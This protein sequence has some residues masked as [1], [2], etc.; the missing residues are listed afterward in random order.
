M[1]LAGSVPTLMSDPLLQRVASVFDRSVR[2]RG[3]QYYHDGHVELIR[4][5]AESAYGRVYGSDEYKVKAVYAPAGRVL[6]V[7]CD[8]P[9]VESSGQACKHIW[10]M[11]LA[12]SE[13][14]M[15]TAA[16]ALE[17]VRL[18]AGE[19]GPEDEWK[20][21]EPA[22]TVPKVVPSIVPPTSAT[23]TMATARARPKPHPWRQ[24]LAEV[25]RASSPAVHYGFQWPA[26]RQLMYVIDAERTQ[27]DG[28]LTVELRSRQTKSDGRWGKLKPQAIPRRATDL[29][30]DTSDRQII[31]MMYGGENR[32]DLYSGYYEYYSEQRSAFALAPALQAELTRMIC[33]TG[34][35]MLR[36]LRGMRDELLTPL[37]WDE[38]PPWRFRVGVDR[39]GGGGASPYAITGVF[40]REGQTMLPSRAVLLTAG[41]VMIT[42]THA[43]PLHDSRTIPWA[44][45]LRKQPVIEVPSADAD[46]MLETLFSV[47]NSPPIELPEELAVQTVRGEPTPCLRIS[48]PDRWRGADR[49][50]AEWSF[51]Y[52]GRVV[53]WHHAAARVF[54][55]AARRVIERDLER[56]HLA[57]AQLRGAGFKDPPT[58]MRDER[59]LE[60]HP[61]LLTQAV[62]QLI[63]AGWRVEAEGKVYRTQGDLRINVVSGTDWFELQGGASFDGQEVS[64][65]ELLAAIRSGTNTIALGDGSI[66]VL[67]EAW[68]ERYGVLAGLGKTSGDHVRFGR[69]QVGLL[70]AM[71]ATMPEVEC[72]AVFQRARDELRQFTGIQ[73]L[74]PPEGF[75]GALRGYQREG[76]GW[77]KFLERF[78]FGGCLAD[79]MGLGKTVQVLAMLESRAARRREGGE[80]EGRRPSLVVA[81]RSLIYN[82][83]QEAAR[84]TPGLRVLDYSDSG[85]TQAPTSL[86]QCDVALATYGTLRRDIA[87]L[88][89]IRFD[90]VILDESQAIKNANTNSAKA[91][92][93]LQADHRLALSGTPVENHLNELWSLLEF[94]NPGMLGGSSVFKRF[95]TSRGDDAAAR[96][97]LAGA[98]RPFVLR[99]TKAQVAKDLPDRIEQTLYCEMRPRQRKQY[100]ELRDYYRQSL[101]QKVA[102]SGLQRSK[103]HVL[104]ALLRLRQAACHPGLIEKALAQETSAK[105]EALLPQLTEVVEEGHKALVFS[106][107]TSMLAIV[108]KR[109]DDAGIR[110]EYLDGRTRDRAERVQR[111]QNDADRS[112][113]LISLKAGGVGLNLTAAGYVFLLDP[114]WNPAVEAQAIDRAHRI[115]QTRQVFAYRLIT[116][117]TVEEKVLQL[118]QT[119]RDLADA[120]INADNNL[121]RNLSAADLELLLS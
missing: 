93:L 30:P 33:Q 90:Y 113:F 78:G 29:L 74:D 72:D 83:A 89:D 68:L 112:V 57:E 119:K 18:R 61:K 3:E 71:L 81:P 73:P 13:A 5:G 40:E 12:A 21:A 120:I 50:K 8:C 63:G 103:I 43:A 20:T 75:V 48:S 106:Q 51:D 110:Y 82:W 31:A 55:A 96:G 102:K 87:T 109:L 97:L 70:D 94:L 66:G 104:E 26:D 76:L 44:M 56:E 22:A 47:G 65:P 62:G 91:A 107:F 115:G 105:L 9:Y 2:K 84:F 32:S 34:R 16:V 7:A 99:R 64:L 25:V 41:G 67:P 69:M 54:D 45:A 46:A 19:G 53:P 49:L 88:K 116:R 108:R 77:L 38:G 1:R 101:M 52:G 118:Q 39:R 11:L 80:A 58:H 86:K 6:S 35:A 85:R 79:D 114:W 42:H 111:F 17:S 23:P 14:K 60:L 4:G 28:L 27:R 15:L 98:I 10:A 117:D 95:V 59:I 37:A 36:Q 24:S 92:R 121:I 100:D